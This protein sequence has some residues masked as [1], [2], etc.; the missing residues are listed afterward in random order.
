MACQSGLGHE[1]RL[2]RHSA[3]RPES[4]S[5]YLLQEIRDAYELGT[6]PWSS[7]AVLAPEAMDTIQLH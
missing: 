5:D 1:A 6:T 3:D 7:A 4:Q 2:F